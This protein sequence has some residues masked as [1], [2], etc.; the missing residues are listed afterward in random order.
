MSY[1]EYDYKL[2]NGKITRIDRQTL[3][4]ELES[5]FN[6]GNCMVSP[7]DETRWVFGR[8]Y[9]QMGDEAFKGIEPDPSLLDV[10]LGHPTVE[11][12]VVIGIVTIW[13]IM[14]LTGWG[15][16]TGPGPI[17]RILHDIAFVT[18]IPIN[19][20]VIIAFVSVVSLIAIINDDEVDKATRRIVI[21]L[22]IM[23][24][25]IVFGM[26]NLRSSNSDLIA[27]SKDFEYVYR[28][29][30]TEKDVLIPGTN[31]YSTKTLIGAVAGAKRE[32]YFGRLNEKWLFYPS[33]WQLFFIR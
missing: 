21:A 24:P 30:P 26:L 25:L 6:Q 7:P 29:I 19:V 4:G 23:L 15:A 12:S 31:R 8:K 28:E 27:Q 5:V 16:S 17:G 20:A 11:I 13:E 1:K 9:L 2:P 18:G 22:I 33:F 32:N 3:L 10:L 14:N